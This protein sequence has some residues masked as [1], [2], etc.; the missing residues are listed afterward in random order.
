MFRN[1]PSGSDSFNRPSDNELTLSTMPSIFAADDILRTN[2][3]SYLPPNNSDIDII[4]PCTQTTKYIEILHGRLGFCNGQ[5][6]HNILRDSSILKKQIFYG[7]CKYILNNTTV[8]DLTYEWK[9]HIKLFPFQT[10]F[11]E[12]IEIW[13]YAM[14]Q[15]ILEEVSQIVQSVIELI[16]N[17]YSRFVDWIV[18]VGITPILIQKTDLQMP[19]YKAFSTMTERL[20]QRSITVIHKIIKCIKTTCIPSFSDIEILRVRKT[21]KIYS[22]LTRKITE[23]YVYSEPISVNGTLMFTTPIAHLYKEIIKH[24]A[25]RRHQKMCQLLNTFP[26]KALTTA[27]T[28]VTNK[29][30]M[31]L[32]EKEEKNS[33]AKKNL[34]KFLLNLSD[35]KSKIG[36]QDSVES[37]LQDLTP[38]IVDQS[39]LLPSREIYRR[40]DGHINRDIR[41]IFKKQI[42]KC[43]EEQIQNQMDEIETLKTT[44]KFFESKIKDLR[45]IIDRCGN[46]TPNI[47]LDYELD[48]ASLAM[49]LNCVQSIPFNSIYIDDN[50]AVANSFLSQYIPDT[51]YADK[52]L[53]KLWELEYYRTFKLRRNVNNQGVEDSI[54]YSNYTLELLILPFLFK[55]LKLPNLELIPEE[56]LFLSYSEILLIVYENSKLKQYLQLLCIRRLKRTDYKEFLDTKEFSNNNTIKNKVQRLRNKRHIQNVDRPYYLG[57]I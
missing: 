28:E 11:D 20:L 22:L 26:V 10:V 52:R 53:D 18:T 21:G 37:F 25:L 7:L 24:D 3:L 43:M 8:Q 56:F 39:K 51:E 13:A 15:V 9:K 16:N 41:D 14:K 12:H 30:I 6:V 36:I 5:T 32:I 29:R 2:L 19:Q 47:S 4:Y 35:S 44:N 1:H 34:M 27:K 50:R 42:I 45:S 55:V 46:S 17:D 31:E 23:S 54:T 33:D 38:S 40:A 48:D 57:N 49:A